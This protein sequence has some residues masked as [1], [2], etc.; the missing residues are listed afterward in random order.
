[1][2]FRSSIRACMSS[3]CAD[4]GDSVHIARS[5][6]SLLSD[7]F[8]YSDTCQFLLQLYLTDLPDIWNRLCPDGHTFFIVV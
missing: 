8:M 7:M 2:L 6:R 3:C 1:M 4:R 5:T